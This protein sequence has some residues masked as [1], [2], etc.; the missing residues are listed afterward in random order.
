MEPDTN[1]I[2]GPATRRARF[3]VS[4]HG[5]H[6]HGFALN[7]DVA[8]VEA[9]LVKSI[10][11]VTRSKVELSSAGRTDTGVHSR[12]QVVSCDL[13][14]DTNFHRLMRSVNG[15][16]APHISISDLQWTDND[17]DAR[18]SATWRQYRYTVWNAP[19]PDPLVF[20]RSWHIRHPLSLPLMNLACDGIIGHHDFTAFCRKPDIPQGDAEVSMTRY[21]FEASWREDDENMVVFDIRANAFCHKMV[22]SLVGFFVDVGIGKRP[23]SDT[24]AVMLAGDRN[25]GSP[26]APPQGLVFWDVG[27]DGIRIHP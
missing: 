5:A 16:C 11:T 3:R 7:K 24:R 18:R 10:S 2:N 9:L 12:G 23:P 25:H 27:Y 21:V 17:F 19:E 22:R 15:L 13:P 14:A 6:F 4:Y 8:T 26:V 20:D 1:E